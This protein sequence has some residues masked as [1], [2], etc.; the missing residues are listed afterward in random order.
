MKVPQYEVDWLISRMQEAKKL[1]LIPEIRE[2]LETDPLVKLH[3]E[4]KWD[5]MKCERV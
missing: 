1:A 2:L 5:D 3:A 4:K